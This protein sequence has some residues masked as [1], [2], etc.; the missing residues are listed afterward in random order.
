MFKKSQKT[1]PASPFCGYQNYT[2]G[3]CHIS[4]SEFSYSKI[5][6][7]K[8][9]VLVIDEKKRENV[10]KNSQENEGDFQP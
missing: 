3:Y 7:G 10:I 5:S 2:M 8:W 1:L 6:V 4:I 9:A